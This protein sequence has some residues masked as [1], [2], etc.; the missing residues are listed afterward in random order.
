MSGNGHAWQHGTRR[1]LFVAARPI[2]LE[3]RSVQNNTQKPKRKTLDDRLGVVGLAVA[4]VVM[5]MIFPPIGLVCALTAIYKLIKRNN[6][7]T[8]SRTSKTIAWT[9]LALWLI[10]LLFIWPL[11]M[12]GIK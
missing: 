7:P 1:G 5:T 2:N 6:D 11:V 10:E 9:L 8:L 3:G 12:E 4:A